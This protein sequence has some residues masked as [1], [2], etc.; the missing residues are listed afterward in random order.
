MSR[1]QEVSALSLATERGLKL[2]LELATKQIAELQERQEMSEQTKDGDDERAKELEAAQQHAEELSR[3]LTLSTAGTLELQGTVAALSATAASEGE[4]AA[5]VRQELEQAK[6]TMARQRARISAL[7][8]DLKQARAERGLDTIDGEVIAEEAGGGAWRRVADTPGGSSTDDVPTVR[9]TSPPQVDGDYKRGGVS[10]GRGPGA[11]TFGTAPTG[12][13]GSPLRSKQAQDRDATPSS[14]ETDQEAEMRQWTTQPTPPRPAPKAAGARSRSA[15]SA[16]S[17][18]RSRSVSPPRGARRG[19][20]GKAAR[21]SSEEDDAA[22]VPASPA[23]A[24]ALRRL[25]DERDRLRG[26]LVEARERHRAD[27][28]Q[29]KGQLAEAQEA[30]ALWQHECAAAR[31]QLA[32]VDG[33]L[34]RRRR[35]AQ[36]AKKAKQDAKEAFEVRLPRLSRQ[37]QRPRPVRESRAVRALLCAGGAHGGERGAGEGAARG[38]GG[39]Q[40]RAH[41]VL[42]ACRAL[43][44]L[45]SPGGLN[46]CSV[47][48]DDWLLVQAPRLATSS[49]RREAER[50]R[51]VLAFEQAKLASSRSSKIPALAPIRNFD[52]FPSATQ[53][54]PARIA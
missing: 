42:T 14:R 47:G 32:A 11:A 6:E 18:P 22:S 5:A 20:R 15:G 7:R 21:G 38:Q 34:K 39:G 30:A 3:E 33:E 13:T 24:V 44:W 26:A 2:D 45:A 16:R 53:C 9:S 49:G 28:A 43:P 52:C 17:Q 50:R 23:S 51:P 1:L 29:L 54:R 46:A 48:V 10:W 8:S 41:L 12:R 4:A 25:L 36:L 19:R 35:S 37:R 31:T 27:V 40:G